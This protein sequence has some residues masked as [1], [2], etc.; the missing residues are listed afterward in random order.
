MTHQVL[1][2]YLFNASYV[3]FHFLVE[4]LHGARLGLQRR[5]SPDTNRIVCMESDIVRW[6][7][8]GD[9]RS[10][11]LFGHQRSNASHDCLLPVLDDQQHWSVVGV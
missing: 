7:C 3:Y 10:W 11:H 6:R 5:N 4:K 1:Q 9:F 2:N 8:K